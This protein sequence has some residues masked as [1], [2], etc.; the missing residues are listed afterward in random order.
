MWGHGLWGLGFLGYGRTLPNVDCECWVV[1]FDLTLHNDYS[2]IYQDYF[3]ACWVVPFDLPFHN[4]TIAY[5]I[6]LTMEAHLKNVTV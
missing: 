5:Q 4:G 3:G 2:V 1:P 6:K